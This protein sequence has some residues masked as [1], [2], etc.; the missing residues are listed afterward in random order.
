MAS[1]EGPK[2][3]KINAGQTTPFDIFKGRGITGA[4]AATA[5]CKPV[6]LHAVVSEGETVLPI[7]PESPEGLAILRHSASH[8]MAQAIAR[9]YPGA[10]FGVGPSIQDGF[11]YDVLFPKPI[12]EE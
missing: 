11:Y 1:F 6:D 9:L 3:Q 4:I 2:T 10:Q 7:M 8:L 5:G 12:S